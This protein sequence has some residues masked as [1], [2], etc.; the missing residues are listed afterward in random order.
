LGATAQSVLGLAQFSV[1]GALGAWLGGNLYDIVGPQVTFLMAG[2]LAAAGLALFL[3]FEHYG[4]R[5]LR[6]AKASSA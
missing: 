5:R 3:A 1:G 6:L 2:F 4:G